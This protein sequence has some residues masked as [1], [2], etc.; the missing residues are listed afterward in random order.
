MQSLINALKADNIPL[1]LGNQPSLYKKD[2][3]LKEVEYVIAPQLVCQKNGK[4]Y[5]LNSIRNGL[6]AFNTA[7]KKVAEK[8]NI[9]FIDLEKAVPKNTSFFVDSVHY[10]ERGNQALAET[11]FTFISRGSYIKND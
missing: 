8:N 3:N 1:I 9:A 2:M 10:T 11:L 6:S 7:T 4:Y 5:S